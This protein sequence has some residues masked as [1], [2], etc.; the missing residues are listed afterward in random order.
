VSKIKTCFKGRATRLSQISQRFPRASFASLPSAGRSEPAASEL[1]IRGDTRLVR[2]MEVLAG[3]SFQKIGEDAEGES[4][5]RGGEVQS[6]DERADFFS[7]GS[8][9]ASFMG[10]CWEALA[11]SR[12]DTRES[13]KALVRRSRSAAWRR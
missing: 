13:S 6:A 7:V 1:A 2:A 12:C 11:N 5:I 3:R 10:S 9:G 4:G 8:G